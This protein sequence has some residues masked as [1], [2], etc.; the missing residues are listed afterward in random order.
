MTVIKTRLMFKGGWTS[1]RNLLF[2]ILGL[3]AIYT[4]FKEKGWLPKKSIV[5]KHVFIT[6]AGS[7]IGRLMAV[8][9]AKMGALL[10]LVDLNSQG[11]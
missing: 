4:Y 7:G 1:K 3:W 5:K 11:L 10:T 2:L 9:M 6:G 8:R